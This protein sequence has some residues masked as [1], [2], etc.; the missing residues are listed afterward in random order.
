MASL[1]FTRPFLAV[2]ATLALARAAV[3]EDVLAP[4]PGPAPEPEGEVV[5]RG[6]PRVQAA[7]AAAPGAAV[8]VVDAARFAGE[9]KGAGELLATS[10]GVA[11]T[12]H[13]GVG[14]HASVSIRGA[15]A[16]QVK[17]LL[18]GV[19]LNPSAGGGVDLSSIPPQWISRVE[20]VRGTEGV[21]HG[22]GALGGVVNVV[23][24]APRPGSWSASATGGSF[25]TYQADAQ[26][27]AGGERWGLLGSFATSRSTGAFSYWRDD[28]TA[29]GLATREH[30]A[31]E[32]AGALLKAYAL[33]GGGRVDAAAQLSAGRRELPG[34]PADPTPLDWQEDARGI[35]SARFRVPGPAGA[36]LSAS[37]STRVDRVAARLRDLAGVVVRQQGVAGTGSL[38]AD[39]CGPHGALSASVEAG[40]EQLRGGRDR[41][42]CPP[43]LR[44]R[45]VGRAVRARPRA[46]R[47]R[48]AARADGATRRRLRQARRSASR[49]V[50]RCRSARAWAH[51]P[52]PELLRAVSGTGRR[53][54]EP[55]ASPRGRRSAATARSSPRAPSA[56]PRSAR[57]R[58]CTATSSCT[59][60][61]RSAGSCR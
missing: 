48:R 38:A 23:T 56:P 35:L 53:R 31:S 12:D 7:A 40:G 8:T 28:P 36:S 58:R 11:V 27:A 60:R 44:A 15:S 33:A 13:G 51:L 59:S 26:G 3:A 20:V 25:G 5:I 52:R 54:A 19:P 49:S 47:A 2:V 9:A 39:W 17:I 29:P 24:A 4:R 46:D 34:T 41:G 61:S 32:L 1:V 50:G 14:R 30:D 37:G 43:D 55:R 10:P 22:T 57:S 6:A 16:E 21:H 42:P 18:D 45:R